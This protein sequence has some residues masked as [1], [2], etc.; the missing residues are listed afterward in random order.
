V[1]N[2]QR[3]FKAALDSGAVQAWAEG[4]TIECG[5]E[6]EWFDFTGDHPRFGSSD[7]KWRVKPEPEPLLERWWVV[8]GR[9]VVSGFE[10]REGASGYIS[11]HH[12][13]PSLRIVHMREVRDATL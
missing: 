5:W 13:P 9:E 2:E 6:G 11:T 7:F 1:I 10:T 12:E 4:K 8:R 3:N